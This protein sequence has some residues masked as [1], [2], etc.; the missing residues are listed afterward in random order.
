DLLATVDRPAG[1]GGVLYAVGNENS[2]LTVF[3]KDDRLAFDY[4]AFGDHQLVRSEIEVPVGASVLG[5]RFR[6]T[7]GAPS[8]ATLVVDDVEV[9]TTEIPLV[10]GMISSVGAS[11]GHDRGSAVSPEYDA[12]F[13]F[14]G[15]L[16]RVDIQLQSQTP[17]QAEA[18]AATAQRAE[19]SRQ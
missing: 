7:R 17:A 8:T 15:T 14:E 5:V 11:V 9:G 10:L 18:A 4:N 12:P 3:V 16:H 6:R 19:E 1:A 13:P 2:G